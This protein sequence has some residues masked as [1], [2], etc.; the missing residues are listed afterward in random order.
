MTESLGL[1]LFGHDPEKISKRPVAEEEGRP[2]YLWSTDSPLRNMTGDLDRLALFAGQVAGQIDRI[3]S[4]GELTARIVREAE[5]ILGN[6]A[7]C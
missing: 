5:E 7:A 6:L 3:E 2:L 1:D 4:A